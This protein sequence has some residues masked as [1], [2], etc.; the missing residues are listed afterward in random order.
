MPASSTVG[1]NPDFFN[2][3][4]VK[5]FERLRARNHAAIRRLHHWVRAARYPAEF[6]FDSLDGGPIVDGVQEALR[7]RENSP[8]IDYEDTW[9][10]RTGS[11]NS[12]CT[13]PLSSQL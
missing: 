3:L 13:Y 6:S 11:R 8:A 5:I 1:K 2:I 4:G 7:T 12:L 10:H 9:S